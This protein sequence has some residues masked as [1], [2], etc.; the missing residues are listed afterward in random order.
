M[1]PMVWDE[2]CRPGRPDV[3]LLVADRLFP[4]QYWQICSGW[5]T[6]DYWQAILVGG[7]DIRCAWCCR[8][9]VRLVVVAGGP[10]RQATAVLMRKVARSTTCTTNT[11]DWSHRASD[12]QRGEAIAEATTRWQSSSRRVLRFATEEKGGKNIVAEGGAVSAVQGGVPFGRKQGRARH[13]G[14]LGKCQT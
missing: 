8:S 7:V 4:A 10:S 9:V 3:R 2:K 6:G 13:Q 5:K 12:Q 11:R 1:L 14:A